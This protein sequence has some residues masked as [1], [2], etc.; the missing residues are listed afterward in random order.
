M[1]RNVKLKIELTLDN[2]AF[3]MPY[4]DSDLEERSATEVRRILWEMS[5]GQAR[6]GN[7][8]KGD[9]GELRDFNGHKVGKWSVTA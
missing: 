3:D 7:F 4:S 6:S 1:K 9:K 5:T 8:R 2:A